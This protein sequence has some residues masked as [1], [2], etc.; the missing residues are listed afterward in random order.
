LHI[1]TVS[2]A[3]SVQL[4]KAKAKVAGKLQQQC[5]ISVDEKLEGFDTI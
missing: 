3:K 1:P 4:I 5:I 2:T